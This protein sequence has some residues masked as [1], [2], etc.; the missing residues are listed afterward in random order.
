MFDKITPP[1]TGQNQ[2]NKSAP[3]AKEGVEDIFSAS[4][5]FSGSGS[6]PPKPPVFQPKTAFPAAPPAKGAA[7]LGLEDKLAGINKKYFLLGL[8]VLILLVIAV[9]VWGIGKYNPFSKKGENASEVQ[10]VTETGVQNGTVVSGETATETATEAE[11]KT[12]TEEPVVKPADSDQDGLSDEEE[13]SLKTD[14]NNIDSDNDG[15]FDREEV[16]VYATDPLKADTDGDGYK[17]G[18]EVKNGYNPKGAGRL[19]EIK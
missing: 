13:K 1:G 19:Y 8:V 2:D 11:N 9:G 16:K 14:S 6:L 18:A 7:R 5:R 10:P 15:L 4:D 3:T 12:V 17:D